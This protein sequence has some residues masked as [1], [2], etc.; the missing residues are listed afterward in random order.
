MHIMQLL[1]YKKFGNFFQN[2]IF[3]WESYAKPSTVKSA[4]TIATQYNFLATV[5][6]IHFYILKTSACNNSLAV[7]G[8]CCSFLYHKLDC[9]VGKV[10]WTFTQ[11]KYFDIGLGFSWYSREFCIVWRLL[12]LTTCNI[13][14]CDARYA[15]IVCFIEIKLWWC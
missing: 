10:A 1:Y 8:A 12:A 13:I 9:N 6:F 3:P 7:K 4:H 11:T 14:F 5:T 15:I 2:K